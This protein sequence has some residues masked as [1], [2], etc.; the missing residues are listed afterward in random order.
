MALGLLLIVMPLAYREGVADAIRGTVLWPVLSLQRGAADREGR[1]AEVERLRAER[2]SLA[3]FLVGQAGLAQ[4]NRELRALLGFR[5][6]LGWSFAAAEAR[7]MYTEGGAT[8]SSGS[9]GTL[10]LS[11]GSRDGV[12]EG[13]PVVTAEGLVGS[14]QKAGT[15]S[16][17][18]MDWTNPNFRVS[19]MT[20]DGETYGI[21]EPGEGPGGERMLM[22]SPNA[23]HTAPDTGAM[24]VTSGDGQM[25]P[26][27]IPIGKVV[28]SGKETSG[29]QRTYYIRPLVSP[30]QS[31]HVLVLGQETRAP[32]DRD[33]AAAWGIRLTGA[34]P[35]DSARAL[36]PDAAAPAPRP[37]APR[38]APARTQPRTTPRRVDPT[39]GL[40][41]RPVFPDEPR[42]P[43]GLPAPAARPDTTERR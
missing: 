33:L 25:Y 12:R 15:G 35:A 28:G 30:A 41:G 38:P 40:P 19:A 3:S 21:A 32:T 13:S 16:S 5:E 24:I 4:E 1:Y 2:D 26:R 20:T 34:P 36:S 8:S 6:R 14:V 42:V 11:A 39:P 37:A 43:P 10:Q 9:F 18:A 23:L 17:L 7:R 22:L 27:G 29:W 31:S